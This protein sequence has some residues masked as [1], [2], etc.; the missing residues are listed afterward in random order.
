MGN[1]KI[2]SAYQTH[3]KPTSEKAIHVEDRPQPSQSLDPFGL[4]GH[5]PGEDLLWSFFY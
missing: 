4:F 2:E 3:A 5:Q 1:A